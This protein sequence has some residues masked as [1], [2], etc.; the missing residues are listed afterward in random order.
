MLFAKSLKG[1]CVLVKFLR[2]RRIPLVAPYRLRLVNERLPKR[3]NP[4]GINTLI[5]CSREI[6]RD[7]AKEG[8]GIT[9]RKEAFQ[10]KLEHV[11]AKEEH[12]LGASEN[13]KITS[14]AESMGVLAQEFIAPCMECLDRRG[15]ISVGHQA[16]DTCLHLFC[17]AVG[18]R[19]GEDLFW[20]GTLARNKPR[21]TPSNDLCL[22]RPCTGNNEEWTLSVCHGGVLLVIQVVDESC[23]VRVYLD[24]PRRE[25]PTPDGYLFIAQPTVRR[26]A[27]SL[28]GAGGHRFAEPW[29]GAARAAAIA[30]PSS[31]PIVTS[32]RPAVICLT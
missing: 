4:L 6:C 30:A 10:P 19:Q 23:E 22:T 27:A 20:K 1:I 32:P 13:A 14:D 28:R 11:L 9:E 25:E 26:F 2:H 29:R 15:C 5:F 12:H 18:K 24:W 7:I 8:G 21:D 31:S 16:V 17:C 3:S